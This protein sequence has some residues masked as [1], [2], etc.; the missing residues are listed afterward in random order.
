MRWFRH[1][2]DMLE[3][4]QSRTEVVILKLLKGFLETSYRTESE[5]EI[6]LNACGTIKL[7]KTKQQIRRRRRCDIMALRIAKLGIV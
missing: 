3:C 5:P 2:G 7:D 4:F 6:W 1:I